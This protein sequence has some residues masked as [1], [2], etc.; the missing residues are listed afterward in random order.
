MWDAFYNTMYQHMN[1][2]IGGSAASDSI[3]KDSLFL[4][5]HSMK[6]LEGSGRFWKS[7]ATYSEVSLPI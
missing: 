4:T 5:H 6:T 1:A 3:A 7:S 2:G